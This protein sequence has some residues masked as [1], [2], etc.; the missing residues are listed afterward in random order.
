LFYNKKNLKNI[1]ILLIKKK[2]I[3]ILE[4]A[5]IIHSL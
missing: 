1:I 5:K 2:K 3:I 4:K